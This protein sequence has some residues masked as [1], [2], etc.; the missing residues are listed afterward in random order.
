MVDAP[1][2][3]QLSRK[4]GFRLP[5]NTVSV[6][7]TRR[8]CGEGFGNPFRI[9]GWF[10]IGSPRNWL[11][12]GLPDLSWCES[13]QPGE[14]GFTHI[15]TRDQ[16]VDFYRRLVAIHPPGNLESLRGKNL[17]CWCP[18][19]Q[20]CH[21]DVLLQLANAEQPAN[22]AGRGQA[23]VAPLRK[24]SGGPSAKTAGSS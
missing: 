4:K 18:L 13:L 24:S 2:R 7:R 9:G 6:A 23:E 5:E 10:K 11:N 21:A 16:A 17:A 3:I 19:D 20:P 14:K 8:I 1:R 22:S 12:S 15:E